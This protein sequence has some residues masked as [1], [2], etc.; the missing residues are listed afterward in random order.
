MIGENEVEISIPVQ[1][2]CWESWNANRTLSMPTLV[3]DRQYE[4]SLVGSYSNL[5]V[6]INRMVTFAGVSTP[7]NPFIYKCR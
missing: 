3:M 5:K 6:L 7:I 1:V 2:F 4:D